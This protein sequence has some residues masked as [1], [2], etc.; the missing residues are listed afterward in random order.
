[1]MATEAQAP[2]MDDL[3]RRAATLAR[4]GYDDEAICRGV[5]RLDPLIRLASKDVPR[6]LYEAA[7]HG[8]NVTPRVWAVPPPGRNEGALVV[9]CGHQ[10]EIDAL[11]GEITRLK[12]KVTKLPRPRKDRSSELRDRVRQL[13]RGRVELATEAEASIFLDGWRASTHHLMTAAI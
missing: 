5:N 10:E 9:D 3:Y 1:M 2:T 11:K 12:A 4:N 7:E 8:H 13:T 6:F